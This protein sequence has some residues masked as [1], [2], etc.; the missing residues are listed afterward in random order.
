MCRSHVSFSPSGPSHGIGA[1]INAPLRAVTQ[2]GSEGAVAKT[3]GE[4]SFIY[5]LYHKLEQLYS[6][7][8]Q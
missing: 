1:P 8:L 7:P 5:D 2:N 4:G 6:K 3:S